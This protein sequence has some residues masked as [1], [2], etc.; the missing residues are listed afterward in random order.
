[1]NNTLDEAS[2]GGLKSESFAI[3]Q[4]MVSF[5]LRSSCVDGANRCA[6]FCVVLLVGGVCIVIG[7]VVIVDVRS[8]DAAI[9]IVVIA[10]GD[11]VT[12]CVVVIIIITGGVDGVIDGVVVVCI[13]LLVII[14][15]WGDGVMILKI[16][17]LVILTKDRLD[18]VAIIVE[19]FEVV[20]D[21]DTSDIKI[22][23]HHGVCGKGALGADFCG[24]NGGDDIRSI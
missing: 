9:V 7:I 22:A 5:N 21:G 15:K 17:L 1:M 23:G 4:T 12:H 24:E 19:I 6:N 3:D 11:G 10:C 18:C 2:G 16:P 8:I 20:Q 13:L 14:I